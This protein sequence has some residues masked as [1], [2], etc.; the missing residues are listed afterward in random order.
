MGDG[1]INIVSL[2]EVRL[3][4]ILDRIWNSTLTDDLGQLWDGRKDLLRLFALLSPRTN[5]CDKTTAEIIEKH[6]L[7]IGIS[8]KIGP[9]DATSTTTIAPCWASQQSAH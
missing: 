3:E 9:P 8:I 5:E 2:N 1:T 7:D 6:F 4:E